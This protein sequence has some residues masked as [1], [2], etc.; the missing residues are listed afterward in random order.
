MV[1]PLENIAIVSNVRINVLKN[2]G[3]IHSEQY[4]NTGIITS[5]KTDV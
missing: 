4:D 2:S 1:K 3:V 5:S